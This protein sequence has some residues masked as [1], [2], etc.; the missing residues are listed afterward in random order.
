MD[1]LQEV[2][3]LLIAGEPLSQKYRDHAL[4]GNYKGY[5][6]C[7]VKPDWLLVYYIDGGTIVFA[8]TGSHAD[9]FE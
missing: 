4:T 1:L 8:K 7:H 9:L 3:N 5:R 2:M 6:E